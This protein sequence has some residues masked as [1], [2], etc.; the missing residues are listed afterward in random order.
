MTALTAADVTVI[1]PTRNRWDILRRTLDALAQQTV[2]GFDVIVVVD[3]TDQQPP[4]LAPA[5]VVEKEHGGPGAARNF[6][7]AHTDRPLVLFLGDDMIPDQQ[8]IERHVVR[9]QQQPD[10][11]VGVLGLAVWHPDVAAGEIQRW[12]DWSGLQFEYAKIEGDDAGPRR[13]YSCN[14]SMK[15]DFFTSVGG[16]DEDFTYYYEDLDIAA[17]L[18]QRGFVLKFERAA[19]TRHLHH[20]EWPDIQRRFSGIAQG[21]WLMA[22]KHPQFRPWFR[23]QVTGAAAQRRIVLPWNRVVPL[24]PAGSSLRGKLERRATRRYLQRMAPAFEASWREADQVAVG[25]PSG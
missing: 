22:R 18:E 7:V 16:F 8:L 19:L 25:G 11:N 6:G 17:R 1:I 24:L 13:F 15:R 4:E 14:V 9:H 12:L 5:R 21:E 20:Y 2:Q 10:P 3:G 23:A